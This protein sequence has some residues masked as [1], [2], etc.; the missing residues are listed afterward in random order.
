VLNFGAPDTFR[1]TRPV[2]TQT[3]HYR[4]FRGA[5]RY[6][7][8]D[9]P[10]IQ[11]SNGSLRGNARLTRWTVMN[12]VASEVRAQKSEVTG[13]SGV[14]LDCL[15]QQDDKALKQWTAPNPNGRAP[16]SEQWQSGAPL[17]CSV[18]PSPATARKWLGAINT[19]QPPHS[20]SSKPSEIFIHCKSKVQHSKTQSKQSIHSKFPKSNLALKGL[21]ED[22][23][24][25]F[26][27]SCRLDCLLPFSFHFSSGL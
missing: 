6:N 15:V 25:S 17:D 5:L 10:V 22:L 24:C 9:F 16:D 12:S 26:C 13:L 2:Q 27:C 3:S 4:E 20:K 18:H 7:S 23:F 19:P 8:P 21:W 14:A 1:C 11:W